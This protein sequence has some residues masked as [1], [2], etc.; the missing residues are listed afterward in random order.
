MAHVR[1]FSQLCNIQGMY[2]I[3]NLSNFY[4]HVLT[5]T[6]RH[7][8]WWSWENDARLYIGNDLPNLF[9]GSLP[10]SLQEFRMELESLERKKDQ[11][12]YVASQMVQSWRFSRT[13]GVA[14]TA[15]VE[16]F[17]LDTWRGSST[18]EST[19]WLRDEIA[20]ETLQYYVK[21]VVWRPN[22]QA[23]VS[24]TDR[25]PGIYVPESFATLQPNNFDNVHTNSLEA[26]GVPPG[27]SAE[28][29]KEILIQ[30]GAVND[31]WTS[32]DDGEEDD[33]EVDDDEG[34]DDEEDDDEVDDDE[35]D[36]DEGDDDEE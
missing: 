29:V 8:D 3:L 34:D 17:E 36:D 11:I 33:D 16:D 7:H 18:W 24:S 23:T 9:R 15:Q 5:L 32:E 35:V 19:R 21:T 2:P 31:L 20:P 10:A 13:D 12:D 28:T 1:V 26:A 30:S 22:L 25:L 14:M 27:T 4:P 6:L